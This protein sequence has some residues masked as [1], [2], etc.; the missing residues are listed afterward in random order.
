MVH[1]Q[2]RSEGWRNGETGEKRT[3]QVVV[4]D[5]RFG[6]VGVSLKYVSA[7]IERARP[8]RHGQL[9]RGGPDEISSHSPQDALLAAVPHVLGFKP[10]SPSSW[11][12]S[13]P[14]SRSPASTSRR[15]PRTARHSGTRACGTR[16]RP[17][18]CAP[19][20]GHAWRPSASPRTAATPRWP[21]EHLS[22]RLETVGIT[23]H[24]R[25]WADGC[26]WSE[27]NTGD[28]GRCSPGGRRADAATGLVAGRVPAGR[29][30]EAMAASM[31]GDREPVARPSSSRRTPPPAHPP[32]SGNGHWTVSS[33]SS[34]D[35]NRLTD[36]RRRPPARGAGDHQ[37]PRRALGG[38]D[39]REPHRPSVAMGRHD[40]PRPRRG[41]GARR[42]PWLAFASWLS[43]DGAKAWCALDEVPADQNYSMAAI[44]AGVLHGGL[45]PSEWEVRRSL[46]TGLAAIKTLKTWTSPTRPGPRA[47]VR[48]IG[49]ASLSQR[50]PGPRPPER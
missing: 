3:K 22:N 17:L 37:H 42:R 20:A 5:D 41:P 25:L 29:E 27:F 21:A 46:V 30:P 43:G 18:P 32:P 33:S 8:G 23:T 10:G 44:V 2:L 9:N 40:P 19:A 28:S 35:G 13:G 34:T 7:R 47:H 15:P 6:E 16:W 39:P 38:H 1:G 14:R 11:C 31:V 4:V 24:M 12:R 49:P 50:P 26:V 45:P 36:R 48:Q